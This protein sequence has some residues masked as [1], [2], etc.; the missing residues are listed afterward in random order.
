MFFGAIFKDFFLFLFCL[1]FWFWFL[2]EIGARICNEIALSSICWIHPLMCTLSRWVFPKI[3]SLWS[4]LCDL[5]LALN[6]ESLEGAFTWDGCYIN[7]WSPLWNLCSIGSDLIEFRINLW[8]CA[9]SNFF[10]LLGIQFLQTPDNPR[11]SRAWNFS[12]S[13]CPTFSS[14]ILLSFSTGLSVVRNTF[15][16]K[17]SDVWTIVSRFSW[18]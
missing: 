9:C 14:A 5:K 4:F 15:T 16:C 18:L 11:L 6:F 8:S 1:R 17:P 10:F 12:C 7:L 2:E 13:D 3:S